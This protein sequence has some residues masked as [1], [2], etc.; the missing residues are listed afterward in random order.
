MPATITIDAFETDGVTAAGT[1]DSPLTLAAHGHDAKSAEQFITG[2]T[3]EFMGILDIRS[4]M[5]FAALTV[6]SL[7]NE[8]V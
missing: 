4:T 8:P 3:A 7:Y 1:S 6:R 2:L 5:P